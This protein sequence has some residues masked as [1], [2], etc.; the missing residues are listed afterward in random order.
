MKYGVLKYERYRWYAHRWAAQ[1]IHGQDIDGRQVDHRCNR[2]L[3]MEHLQSIPPEWNR[4]LQ[5]IRVQVGIEDNPRPQFEPDPDA[6][7]FYEPPEW[8]RALA[9]MFSAPAEECPF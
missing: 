6:V 5:W 9:V 7:P 2:P 8:Y 4:E 3:C 1:Y